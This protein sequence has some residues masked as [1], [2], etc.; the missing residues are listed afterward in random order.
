MVRVAQ[1][2]GEP[3]TE[4]DTLIRASLFSE[5]R[6]EK[7][8]GHEPGEMGVLFPTLCLVP[9]QLLALSLGS[10]STSPNPVITTTRNH[11]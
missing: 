4:L 10:P 3:T 11:S 9:A 2:G 5:S 8:M 6:F 1:Q 7:A